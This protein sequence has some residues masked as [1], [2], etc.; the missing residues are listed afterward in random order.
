MGGCQP[1]PRSREVWIN[2]N[3][4]LEHLSTEIYVL[5]GPFLEELPAAQIKFVGFDPGGGLFDQMTSLAL[6]E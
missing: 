1:R 6:G 2:G 5:T 4:A 3:R